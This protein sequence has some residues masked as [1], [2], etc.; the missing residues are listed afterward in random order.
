[1]ASYDFERGEMDYLDHIA[2]TSFDIGIVSLVV[3]LQNLELNQ[4]Q[5]SGLMD[6]M[7][8]NQNKMLKKII[9]QNDLIIK[10]NEEMLSLLKER[11]K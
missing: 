4:Q 2:L 1:M 3:G 7:Q 11:K 8:S 9:E 10:Q 5:V 6:E